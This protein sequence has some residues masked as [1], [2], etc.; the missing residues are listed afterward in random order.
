MLVRGHRVPVLSTSLESSTLDLT[1]VPTPRLGDRVL[2]VGED[3]D[4]R[5]TLGD[6]ARWQ[7][8]SELRVLMEFTG[9]MPVTYVGAQGESS[10]DDSTAWGND[11]PPGTG[12]AVVD[13][14]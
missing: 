2:A 4:A 9:R 14:G 13:T 5:I 6:M 10:A 7:G 12:S 8:T 3:G 11:R 1:G